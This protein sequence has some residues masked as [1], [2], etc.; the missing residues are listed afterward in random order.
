MLLDTK[1]IT[2]AGNRKLKIYGKLNCWSGKRMNIENRVFFASEAEAVVHGFRP[3]GNCMR[4]K[5]TEW[6][7]AAAS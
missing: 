4:E 6:K 7:S 1:Q 5:Y 2:S 3:C